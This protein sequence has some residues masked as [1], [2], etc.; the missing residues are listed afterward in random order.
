MLT[1]TQKGTTYTVTQSDNNHPT[2]QLLKSQTPRLA[3]SHLL[4]GN[5]FP[6]LSSAPKLNY[7]KCFPPLEEGVKPLHKKNNKKRSM[8][9]QLQQRQALVM[10]RWIMDFYINETVW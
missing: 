7:K 3:T 10:D 4:P 2:P 8:Q 6:L 1:V 9:G 5:L